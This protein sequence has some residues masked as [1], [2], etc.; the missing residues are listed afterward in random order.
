[1]R[2]TAHPGLGDSSPPTP[3]TPWKLE[4]GR[5]ERNREKKDEKEKV[6]GLEEEEGR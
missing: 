1:M 6:E 4:G 2:C 5:R 3:I